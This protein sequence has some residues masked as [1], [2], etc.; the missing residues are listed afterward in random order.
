VPISQTIMNDLKSAKL[1]I[2]IMDVDEGCGETASKV[3]QYLGI[4]EAYLVTEAQKIFEPS[5]IDDWLRRLEEASCDTCETCEVERK[6]KEEKVHHR[7]STRPKVDS[8]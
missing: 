6:E 3:E 8:R 1:M 2:K 5:R 4:V 7:R